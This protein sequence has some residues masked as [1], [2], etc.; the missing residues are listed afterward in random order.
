[1]NNKTG[2][3]NFAGRFYKSKAWK[4][5][6]MNYRKLHPLCERCLS[7][8]LYV[9]AEL[10]HHKVHIN[11]ENQH[12]MQILMSDDNLES[13]CRKCHGEEHASREAM[14]FDEEGRLDL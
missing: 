7:K 2:A 1:M 8:G 13:L 4:I 9:P 3:R 14:C 11:E 10:V 5:R 12:D 6:S